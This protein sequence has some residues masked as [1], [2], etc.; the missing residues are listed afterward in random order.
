MT[1]R[2]ILE[3]A[4]A[5]KPEL[6]ML[7]TKEKNNA[8]MAMA[9]ALLEYEAEIL[10]ANSEDMTAAQRRGLVDGCGR[11]SDALQT[12]PTFTPIAASPLAPERLYSTLVDYAARHP[13][14]SR[15]LKPL[16]SLPEADG[17]PCFTNNN[18]PLLSRTTWNRAF[19][20]FIDLRQ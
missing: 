10:T 18:R 17:A 14:A 16:L 19:G 12:V 5:V 9:D 2:E 4:R 1:T 6:A 3:R 11:L 7:T 8:L 20:L 13:V 15:L